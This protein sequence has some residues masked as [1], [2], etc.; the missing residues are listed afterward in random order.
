MVW[1][2]RRTIGP[3]RSDECSGEALAFVGRRR[4]DRCPHVHDRLIVTAASQ[5]FAPSLLALLGSLD[6]NWPGHPAVRVYDIGLAGPTRERLARLGVEVVPVPAFVPHWRAHFTWKLWCLA[7][8]PT[9]DLLWLDAGLV[10]LQPAPEIFDALERDG[11]FLTTNRERLEWEASAQACRGCGVA[12]E[13][14]QGR[15]TLAGTVMGF[16]KVG[17]PLAIVNQALAVA[18]I[19]AHI[20]ATEISHRHDQAILSLLIYDQLGA[21]RVA[22]PAVYLASLSPRQTPGQ[23]IWVHRRTLRVADASLLAAQIGRSGAPRFCPQPAH[24]LPR[25]TA[26]AQL[27]KVHWCFGRRDRTGAQA[28]LRAALQSDPSLGGQPVLLARLLLTYERKLDPFLTPADGH[29]GLARWVVATL[30]RDGERELADTLEGC[31]T[32]VRRTDRA[33]GR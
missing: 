33:L 18:R 11:Y 17:V 10:L 29:E 5:D 25:A 13:L 27:Y 31:L 32:S 1:L 2:C 21:V 12:P 23:R 6:V 20:A 4:P 22:D 14:R 30:A 16:R 8:A 26:L 19:E 9:R 28:Q 24:P 3:A 15:L 7:D